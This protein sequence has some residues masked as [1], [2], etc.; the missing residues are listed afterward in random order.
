MRGHKGPR[1]SCDGKL[2]YDTKR[3]AITALKAML[4][5]FGQKKR[6]RLTSYECPECGKH[7][8]GHNRRKPK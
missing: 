4:D 8:I 3:K 2:A 5:R 6:G 7:H 1:N